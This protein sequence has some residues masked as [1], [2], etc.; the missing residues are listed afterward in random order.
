LAWLALRVPGNLA[1]CLFPC[2]R[3]LPKP[4]LS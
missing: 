4:S 3:R 1:L 2:R